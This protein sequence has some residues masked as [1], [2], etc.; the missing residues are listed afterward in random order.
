MTGGGA[1]LG[2]GIVRALAAMGADVAILV[3]SDS[4]RAEALAA[5][6]RSSPAAGGGRAIVLTADMGDPDA[7]AAAADS[8]RRQLGPVGVL[9]HSAAHRSVRPLGELDVDEWRRTM[10]VILDGAF[11]AT[12]AVVGGM[13]D[14][15]FGRFVYVGGSALSSGLPAGHGHVA[16]AKA[17]LVGLA[18][19]VAQEFG[20]FGVTANVVSPGPIDTV[21]ADAEAAGHLAAVVRESAVGRVS[22]IDEVAGACAFLASPGAGTITGQVLA[23]DGGLRGMNP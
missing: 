13:V 17:G 14:Q 23:V 16:A 4:A 3:R 15:G 11:F 2:A 9:V 19:T 1:N 8:C 5:E 10:A 22:T 7:V 20:P 18:R 21:R 12:R 6:I